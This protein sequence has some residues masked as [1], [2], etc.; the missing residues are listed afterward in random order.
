M[1]LD[2]PIRAPLECGGIDVKGLKNYLPCLLAGLHG[3]EYYSASSQD[4]AIGANPLGSRLT[5]CAFT[6]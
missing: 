6:T 2:L 3:S 5:V 1:R 4:I